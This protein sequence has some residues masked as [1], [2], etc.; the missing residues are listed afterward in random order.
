M[1][2][3][4]KKGTLLRK[5]DK[6]KHDYSPYPTSLGY[7]DSTYM[8]SGLDAIY[9]DHEKLPDGIKLTNFEKIKEK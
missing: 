1:K 2:V 8:I 6:L 9:Y 3:Y 7:H 4:D 5:G